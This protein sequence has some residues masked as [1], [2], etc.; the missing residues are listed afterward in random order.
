MKRRWYG[1]DYGKCSVQELHDFIKAKTG[2]QM[3]LESASGKARPKVTFINKLRSIELSATF[4]FM[5]LPPEMRNLIYEHLLTHDGSRGRTASTAILRTD[6][7]I[8]REAHG[9][10]M[11]ESVFMFKA[12][13]SPFR[14]SRYQGFAALSGDTGNIFYCQSEDYQPILERG[15]KRAYGAQ[16]FIVALQIRTLD[17]LLTAGSTSTMVEKLLE[18][19]CK[20]YVRVRRVTIELEVLPC[21]SSSLKPR[22]KIAHLLRPLLQLS[23]DCT[24]KLKGLTEQEEKDFWALGGE[25]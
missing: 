10:L 13:F 12:R 7:E 19:F 17:N 2:E 18:T 3:P 20:V 1:L 14:H 6:R 11:A 8:Y 21:P 25:M 22:P 9:I 24:L 4:R 5:D 16:N 23:E 15:L